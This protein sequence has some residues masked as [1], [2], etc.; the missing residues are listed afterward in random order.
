MS[1]RRVLELL[2]DVELLS[3]EAVEVVVPRELNRWAVRGGGLDDDFTGHFTA[4]S[5]AGNLG[6]ELEGAFARAKVGGVK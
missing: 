3:D 2:A 1:E 5:P 4:A 6:E